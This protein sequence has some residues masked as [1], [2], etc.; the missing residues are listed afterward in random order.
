MLLLDQMEENHKRL[1]AELIRIQQPEQWNV[2]LGLDFSGKDCQFF[3]EGFSF[4]AESWYKINSFTLHWEGIHSQ[5]RI[6]K[7]LW[8][9]PW[10]MRTL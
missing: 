5:Q 1:D 4:Q 6:N 10:F 8:I 2:L 7:N 3:Y 9:N